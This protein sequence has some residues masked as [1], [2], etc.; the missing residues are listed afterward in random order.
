MAMRV[1]GTSIEC[2]PACGAGIGGRR[3]IQYHALSVWRLGCGWACNLDKQGQPVTPDGR[4]LA[5]D[6]RG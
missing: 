6:G 1:P 2:C 3:G 5:A 4:R